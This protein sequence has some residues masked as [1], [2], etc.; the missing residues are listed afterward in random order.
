MAITLFGSSLFQ[1]LS[2]SF[3]NT[4]MALFIFS[5]VMSGFFSVNINYHF[6]KLTGSY[7]PCYSWNCKYLESNWRNYNSYCFYSYWFLP[8]FYNLIFYLGNVF[9]LI[10][11][12]AIGGFIVE[13]DIKGWGNFFYFS[14]IF[15]GILFYSFKAQLVW[16]LFYCGFS[17]DLTHLIP[18]LILV[19]QNMNILLKV[20][21]RKILVSTRLFI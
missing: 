3:A 1:L 13:R 9:G 4:N 21:E 7:Y 18:I 8:F 17:L 5:R 20:R 2:P 15:S 16:L 11:N 10:L 6:I 12:Y 14:G 19:I